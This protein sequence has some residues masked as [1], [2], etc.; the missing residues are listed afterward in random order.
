MRSRSARTTGA[1]TLLAVFAGWAWW[2]TTAVAEPADVGARGHH[3]AACADEVPPSKAVEPIPSDGP[4]QVVTV[5]V[6]RVALIESTGRTLNARTNTG[7]PPQP[8]AD[9]IY[10]RVRG[11]YE[12]ADAALVARIAGADWRAVGAPGECRPTRWHG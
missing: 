4:Q 12:P 8:G 5:A 2:S 1:L 7:E 10:V 11:T 3:V 9:E 6:P